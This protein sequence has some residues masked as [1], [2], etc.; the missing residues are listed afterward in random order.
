MKKLLE[1]ADTERN[2][3]K[4]K[5]TKLEEKAEKSNTT[6]KDWADTHEKMQLANIATI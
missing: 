1:E 3:T 5:V 2:A 6:I 4:Q